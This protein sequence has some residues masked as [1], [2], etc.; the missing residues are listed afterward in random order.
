MQVR[1]VREL[2]Q[3]LRLGLHGPMQWHEGKE[4]LRIW[5]GLPSVFL[6]MTPVLRRIQSPKLDSF[7]TVRLGIW[8]YPRW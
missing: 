1:D 3:V 4:E 5:F 6:A 2:R 8:A 7:E